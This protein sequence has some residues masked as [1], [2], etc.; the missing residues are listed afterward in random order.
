VS[1]VL[2]TGAAGFLGSHLCDALLARGEEVIGV[3]NFS[4][5][6]PENL[7]V[8]RAHRA[9]VLLEQDVCNPL[10]VSGELDAVCHLASPASPADYLRL[11]LETLRAGSRGTE[12]AIALAA[13]HGARFVLAS[14]SEVYGN[15]LV[16]PQPETYWGNVN[17]I[18]P[19]SVYDEAKRF[20]EALTAAYARTGCL[21]AGIARIFNTYGPRLRPGDGRVVS[22]FVA[23][24]LAGEPL[25]VYGEGTQTRSFCYVEDLVDGLMRMIDADVLGPVNLGNAV[26]VTVLELAQCVLELTG[27]TSRIVHRPLPAD[28]PTRRRPDVARASELLGWK[29]SV[30]LREGLARTIQWW[31][32]ATATAQ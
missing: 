1:R 14:T 29:A 7:A 22:N 31:A 25:T 26:E 5:G 30:S 3:D 15:P 23:Q 13:E 12:T 17:P 19:R 18:G 28:D 27:S 10:A 4:T 6:R 9:F 21:N 11:P 32:R 20:A 8:A 2:V 16:H 24:A